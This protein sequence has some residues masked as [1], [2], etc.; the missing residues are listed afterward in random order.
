MK[1]DFLEQAVDLSM[2]N[3]KNKLGGP[4]GAVIVRDNE[5][6]GK[7]TNRVTSLN[8]PTAHAEIM[9]IR[10]ACK[11]VASFSLAG[12][13]IYT[14]CEPCPMCL[15]AIYWARISNIYYANSR[16]DA[17]RIG[18]DDSYIY[19]Q[20]PLPNDCRDIKMFKIKSN[21]AIEVFDFWNTIA[22]KIKY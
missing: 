1:S 17:A 13:D 16:D 9:A 10:D 8:D 7:G 12:S 6:I 11:N 15:A 21:Y 4:F 5:I 20:V 14:S 2:E 22:D 18:F 19:D 3:V